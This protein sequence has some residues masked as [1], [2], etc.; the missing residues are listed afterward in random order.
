MPNNSFKENQP[1]LSLQRFEKM[2]I[3][4]RENSRLT[5]NDI[6][7]IW[8]WLEDVPM[9]PQTECLEQSYF[10]FPSG[11]SKMEI[12]SWFDKHY[13]KGVHTLLYGK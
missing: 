11:T 3:N 7:E 2:Q 10:I 4:I 1:V 5:D 8:R 6:E 12:W 13:S 9:N